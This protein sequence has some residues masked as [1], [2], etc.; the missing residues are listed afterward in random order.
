MASNIDW[1]N[2]IAA[3]A[4][5][6]GLTLPDATIEELAEHLDEIYAAA[7]RNGS[8]EAE[9]Q[10][11]ARAAL[12]ESRFD[13]LPPRPARGG[14]PPS[15][16]P[17]VASPA[18]GQSLNLPGAIRL[19]VRQLRLRPGFAVI[20]I[21]VLALGIGASTTV[22]T[23]VDS[24]LLRPLPYADPDRLVTLWDS[25]PRRGSPK[26]L[27]S[28]VTFM[29][30]RSL[31]EFEGAAAWHRPTINLADPGLDPLRVNTIEVSG[32]L[33]DVLGVRPQIGEGFPVGG[34]FFTGEPM[35]VISDRLWR[36][37]YHA[38]RSIVGRQLRLNGGPYTVAGVMPPRFHYP[39][40][41]DVWE[42]LAVGPDAALSLRAFHG[43]GG[44]PEEGHDA[45]TGV[46]GGGHG[47]RAAGQG[48]STEQRSM[49]PA[50]DSAARPA[51]WLLPP[52]ASGARRRG[53]SRAVDRLSQRR[54]AALDPGVVARARGGG[55][56]GDGRG[57]ASTDRAAVR[58]RPGARRRRRG[59]W[60][61]RLD[62]RTAGAG[63]ADSGQHPSTRRG[64]HRSART[65]SGSGHRG[66]D[67]H[68]VLPRAC[69][70]T[71]TTHDDRRVAIG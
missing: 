65:R 8:S 10:R 55:A 44:P 23:V 27:L 1:R 17:F 47:A 52:G 37:R 54:I 33:F 21:L 62:G 22:F 30:Y 59:P 12:D 38:D 43:V 48:V 16:T 36:T 45:R 63:C 2:E 66:D 49:G 53:R 61:P 13:V 3:R 51:A 60:R 26:E 34:P 50:I 24:V 9:A 71:A 58:G 68:R 25:H 15:P 69:R 28:P 29:D 5:T 18:T 11:R 40:D 70:G 56:S 67:D 6:A 64:Q 19:A 32:N 35:I 46:G 39:D 7:L 20:T 4:Q 14:P 41:I 42:R 57:A 31:P